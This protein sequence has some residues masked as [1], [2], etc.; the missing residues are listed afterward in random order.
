MLALLLYYLLCHTVYAAC[1]PFTARP[2]CLSP[3]SPPPPGRAPPTCCSLAII[4]NILQSGLCV[5]I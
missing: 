2:V 5:V 3:C 4:G 1:P